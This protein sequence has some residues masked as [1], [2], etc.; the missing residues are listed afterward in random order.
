M[1]ER[2]IILKFFDICKFGVKKLPSFFYIGLSDNG[3][4]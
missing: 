2:H 1:I 4:N 3:L